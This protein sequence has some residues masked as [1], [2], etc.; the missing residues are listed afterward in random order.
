M[1]STIDSVLT[2]AALQEL[3][4]H[5]LLRTLVQRR[6]IAAAVEQVELDH[7]LKNQAMQ[8]FC[9]QNGITNEEELEA[10]LSDQGITADDLRWQV[11]L[12]LRVQQHCHDHF[13]HKAEAHF[14]ERKNQLDRVVYS[15]LRVEDGFLARELYLRIAADE[16]NFADLAAA[17]AEGPEKGTK[18]I[19]GPVPLTQAHP[20]LA[21][22][23]RTSAPGE[24]LEPF[25]VSD[26]WLVVRLESYTPASFDEAMAEQMASELFN[27]WVQ[28]ETAVKLRHISMSPP[29]GP[30][31]HGAELAQEP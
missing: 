3:R 4:R 31:S 15:L 11:E 28:E 19:V 26:W 14:L 17:Y 1:T 27:H 8:R 25:K 21:E 16:A 10:F 29:G 2:E 13:R 22:R 5:N 7:T 6:L 9:Q 30:S 12:P 23:L 24:L 18:G 20:A